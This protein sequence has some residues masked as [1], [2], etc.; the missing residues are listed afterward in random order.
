MWT[1]D[2]LALLL[3]GGV[4]TGADRD[5]S[6]W[7]QFRG[8]NASGTSASA[9]PPIQFDLRTHVIW[10]VDV[11]WSPSSPAIWE[12]RLFLSTYH[13]GQL[14]TRAYER[15]T[16]RL[17]WERGLKVDRLE[18]FHS[19]EGSPVA[20]TP[21]TDGKHVV[22]YFGSFGLICHGMEGH[23][24]WRLP[25]PVALSGGNYGSGTSP[26]IMGKRVLLNRDQDLNSTILSVD[27]ET[28]RKIWETP[29]PNTPG[30]FGTPVYWNND[31]V[32]E[33]ILAGS[34]QVKGYDLGSGAERWKVNGVANFVCTSP[35]VGGGM[36]FV[37]AW[38]QGKADSSFPLDWPKF[39]QL[40]DKNRDGKVS[41]E[42][43]DKVGW[44]YNRGIDQ[45]LDGIITAADLE[46]IRARSAKAENALL[47]IRPGGRGDITGTHVAW[48]VTRGL[49][50]VPSPLYYDGRIYLVKDGGLISSFDAKSGKALYLQERLGTGGAYYA[51]P[52]AADGRIYVVSV[53]GS[54]TVVKAGGEVPVILHRVDLGERTFASPALTE[55][56]LYVR[57][58]KHL[59]AFGGE[60][61][62]ASSP[63]VTP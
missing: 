50:Y 58:E 23:E 6:W 48:K 33:V 10:Q 38:S 60:T 15:E 61:R 17:L 11:P 53:S 52:V 19:T 32:E 29:R 18:T 31:G 27:L 2:A 28:G 5:S 1:F 44:D 57:T 35:V 26:V 47:A 24:L 43:F 7:P 20:A 21:A 59:Y 63:P 46:V 41:K 62:G 56:K 8:P 25:L 30:G 39:A 9:K 55:D 12:D 13:E 34:L 54:L 37:A 14:Q 51:S 40:N 22:S 42:D 4:V 36:L 49:P 45:D 16:G 3:V